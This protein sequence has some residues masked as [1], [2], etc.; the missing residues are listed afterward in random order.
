MSSSSE[1]TRAGARSTLSGQAAALEFS[2]ASIY[3]S[4]NLAES[5]RTRPRE[6]KDKQRAAQCFRFNS[7][8]TPRQRLNCETSQ[9]LRYIHEL[10]FLHFR[11]L[12]S[13]NLILHNSDRMWWCS[14]MR[15]IC[16]SQLH[17]LSRAFITKCIVGFWA[18][19]W[20]VLPVMVESILDA[21]PLSLRFT[22]SV[23]FQD[24]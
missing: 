4:E 23:I 7:L 6:A 17:L 14:G 9:R 11:L 16:P 10:L 5:P 2:L 15:R 24:S 1:A 19:S 18:S 21:A 20:M 8:S 13:I 22:F 12:S 3:M